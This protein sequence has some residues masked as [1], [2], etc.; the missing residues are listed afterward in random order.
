MK[1]PLFY[2]LTDPGDNP[3][4][5]TRRE[6]RQTILEDLQRLLST[7]YTGTALKEKNILNYGIPSVVGFASNSQPEKA[8]LA[9]YIKEAIEEYEPRLRNVSVE[10][11]NVDDWRGDLCTINA[12]MAYDD[13]EERFRFQHRLH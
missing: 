1:R 5:V 11:M 6:Y 9:R 7:R 4:P 12:T 10:F 8:N 2:R 13:E 3:A